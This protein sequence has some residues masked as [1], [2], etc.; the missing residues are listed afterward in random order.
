MAAE[1]RRHVILVGLEVTDEATYA[2]YRAEMGPILASY[3]GS[4][5]ID[6][7]VARVL[8]GGHE[9]LNRVFTIVFPDPPTRARFFADT[10]YRAVRTAFFEPSVARTVIIGEYDEAGPTGPGGPTG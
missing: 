3:G 4:F 5:G 7:A 8:H 1:G 10:S 9:R 2:R 6:L